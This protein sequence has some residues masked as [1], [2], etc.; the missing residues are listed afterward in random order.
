MSFAPFTHTIN[1]LGSRRAARRACA[2]RAG[3]AWRTRCFRSGAACLAV[4]VAGCGASHAPSARERRG[5]Q[6]TPKLAH[7]LTA[8]LRSGLAVTDIPGVAAAVVFPDGREWSGAAGDANL[9]PRTAM[10]PRT[11]FSFD[12]VTKVATAA[13]TMRLVEQR[14]LRL[15]DPIRRWYPAW[16]GDPRATIRD[17]LGHTSGMGDPP[18]RFVSRMIRHP[19]APL[20]PAMALAATPRP[21]PRTRDAE[22]SNSAFILLG[23]ILRRAA[24]E[25]VATA[26]RRD[27][28]DAPGGEGLALQ[29]QE[30]PHAPL[31]HPY[32]YPQ[33]IGMPVDASDGGPFIPSH[34]W[35]SVAGTTGGLA[36]DVP[37][38][39]RWGHALLGGHILVPRSL[40]AMTRFHDGGF[41]TG[42]G[43]GLADSSI[44]GHPMWGHGGD[45][46]GTHTEF[47]HL[48]REDLTV[49]VSWNDDAVDAHDDPF[50]PH[51]CATRWARHDAR[52]RRST[53]T[54]RHRPRSQEPAVTPID[55]AVLVVAIAAIVVALATS[56]GFFSGTAIG[57]RTIRG[58]IRDHSEADRIRRDHDPTFYAPQGGHHPDPP[59][60]SRPRDEGRLL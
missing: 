36:G 40:R 51:W 13:L 38:L 49:V 22:Y 17:L 28:L 10:T 52:R 31:V 4:L 43:L 27:V 29:P 7:R 19:H 55:I 3:A 47:W 60:M 46:L 34:A 6:L 48:P 56:S 8:D 26:M 59:G 5:P 2:A 20:T 35:A 39:A 54:R 57:S 21:G 53:P 37:S 50:T 42:Y 58:R 44:D 16:R 32:F 12:D 25:P 41:W 11:S 15:D 14:R 33:S 23:L 30:R 45:G 1:V 24:G 18:Q 9:R